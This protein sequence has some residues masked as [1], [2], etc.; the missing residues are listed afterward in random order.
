MVRG[1]YGQRMPRESKEIKRDTEEYRLLLEIIDG[2]MKL[3][4]PNVSLIFLS[5][6]SNLTSFTHEA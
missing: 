1:N 5:R 2:V 6:Q 3:L 4:R